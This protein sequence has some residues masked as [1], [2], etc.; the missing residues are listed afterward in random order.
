MFSRMKPKRPQMAV[1]LFFLAIPL[2]GQVEPEYLQLTSDITKS[3]EIDYLL[4]V[5]PDYHPSQG[6]PLLLYLSGSEVEDLDALRTV[7]PPAQVETGLEF[8]Y[9]IAAP[10]LPDGGV[11]DTDALM[12]L[13]DAIGTSYHVEPTHFWLTGEGDQGGWGA[14]ELALNNPGVFEK[15]AP[16]AASP[17]TQVWGVHESS[18]WIFHGTQDQ[19]VPVEDAEVMYYELNWD[20]T[21][22][23][24]T[25]FDDLGHDIGDTVYSDP[26][27][28]EW[29]SGDLPAV[30]SGSP[31]PR[32]RHYSET[33]SRSVT[34][35]YLLYLPADYGENPNRDWPLVIYLHGSGS[36]IWNIDNIREGGPPLLYEEGTISDFILLCPQLH[37]DVHWDIDRVHAL[38]QHTLANYQIDAS[39]IHITGLSRGGFG[40]W[41]YAV[42][43]PEMLASVVPI[44]ARDVAGV[45]QLVSTPVWIFH[46]DEDTGVPWQGS[47][48]M[49]NRLMAAGSESVNFTLYPGVGHWAWDLAYPT[50]GLWNWILA[51]Q[52][53]YV[54]VEAGSVGPNEFE[55]LQNYPNPFNPSTTIQ[56]ALSKP[57]D[58]RLTIHDLKGHEL[59]VLAAG[60]QAPGTHRLTWNGCNAAGEPLPT[61]VY[62]AR[63]RSGTDTAMTRMLLIR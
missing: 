9:F 28:Y 57:S 7:G 10:L 59:A 25:L 21:D 6:E 30:G 58:V 2:L 3:A 50:Q 16:V 51:Q 52:S 22:V 47:Q 48:F 17:A 23:Q 54:A 39:R 27:F 38:V 4:Y 56:Y 24:L 1:I 8:D 63:L 45:E 35:N 55:L 40:S 19:V 37:D 31:Q 49:Y 36:A 11:W 62:I 12:G 14:W 33:L 43:H 41:E 29:L 44:S 46:G 60:S 13:L 42:T 32:T 20:D 34:D 18:I 61:G 5:P 15:L 26:G 53:E